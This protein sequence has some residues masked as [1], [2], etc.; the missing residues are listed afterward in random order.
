MTNNN[1]DISEPFQSLH[2]HRKRLPTACACITTDKQGIPAVSM[3]VQA[4]VSDNRI[5]MPEL[6][7]VNLKLDPFSCYNASIHPE[8]KKKKKKFC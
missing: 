6:C 8:K 4:T 2:T 7:I 5:E 1:G 3:Y